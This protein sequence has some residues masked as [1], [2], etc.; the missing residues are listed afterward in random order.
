MIFLYNEFMKLS[1][2][3]D[4][5]RYMSP[6]T[7]LLWEND[8]NRFPITTLAYADD[9]HHEVLFVLGS[10]SM[11]L[12]QLFSRLK[13]SSFRTTLLAPNKQPI[14]GFHLDDQ[15]QIIFK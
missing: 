7:R 12:G 11:T 14:F 5:T 4:L 2:L 13:N 9:T 10:K 8:A 6:K 1:D 3:E 15:Y